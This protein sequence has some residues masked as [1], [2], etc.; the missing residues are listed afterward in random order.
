MRAEA[1]MAKRTDRVAWGLA[2]VLAVVVLGGIVILLVWIPPDKARAVAI[3]KRAVEA[4]E[5]WANRA[6]YKAKRWGNGWAVAVDRK[7]GFLGLYRQIGGDRLI[8]IDSRGKVT[9]YIRGY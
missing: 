5:T 7:E 2:T 1:L 3:A 4:N 6:T 8:L 9:D